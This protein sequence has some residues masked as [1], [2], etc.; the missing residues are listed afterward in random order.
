[1]EHHTQ[2]I[3]PQTVPVLWM[4]DETAMVENYGA[5]LTAELLKAQGYM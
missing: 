3:R 1:M 5:I 4:D 2:D